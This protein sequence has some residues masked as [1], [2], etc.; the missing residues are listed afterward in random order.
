MTRPFRLAQGGLIDRKTPLSFR[1]DGREYQGFA[2][3]TLASALLANGVLRVADSLRLGRPRGIFSAGIEEPNAIVQ[4]EEPFPEPMLTATTVEL[5]GGLVARPLR[6]HG[7]LAGDPDP[8]RY[9]AT[10]AHCDVLVIG[11]GPAGLAATATAASS[12]ARVILLD[13]QPRLGGSLLGTGEH[14][15]W[16]EWSPPSWRPRRRPGC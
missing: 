13:D 15:D 16:V 14:L 8:A 3:D 1:F 4:I 6:G 2:G 10:H 5:Y 11:A 7:R 9:N 12:G